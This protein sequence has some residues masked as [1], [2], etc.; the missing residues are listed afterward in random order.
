MV[1]YVC[2]NVADLGLM[3]NGTSF[4]SSGYTKQ[5]LMYQNMSFSSHSNNFILSS[6]Q[7]TDS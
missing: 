7:E 5:F 6:R 4:A 1:K 2:T 3:S